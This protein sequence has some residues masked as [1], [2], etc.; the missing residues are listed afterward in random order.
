MVLVNYENS[1][2]LLSFPFDRF[3]IFS[4]DF[5]S[6]HLLQTVKYKERLLIS[7]LGNYV[8]GLHTFPFKT[9]AVATCIE[10]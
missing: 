7:W 5:F 1:R 4:F 3:F 2:I 6:G 10:D 9:E 8:L